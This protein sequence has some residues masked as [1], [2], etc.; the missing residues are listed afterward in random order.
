VFTDEDFFFDD[1]DEI[2][3][4]ILEEAKTFVTFMQTMVE[5]VVGKENEMMGLLTGKFNLST[6]G[7]SASSRYND[8]DEDEEE[9]DE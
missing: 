5:E 7:R 9:E 1:C 8:D 4:A 6:L 2:H 3:S